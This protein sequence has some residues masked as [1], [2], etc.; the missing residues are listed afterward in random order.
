MIGLVALF[1]LFAAFVGLINPKWRLWLKP[2]SRGRFFGLS[3]AAGFVLAVLNGLL[4]PWE[5]P[6]TEVPSAPES[7]RESEPVTEIEVSQ[8]EY[9]EEWPFTVDHGT[10]DCVD[11]DAGLNAAAVF[12]APGIGIVALNGIARSVRGVLPTEEI[13]RDNPALPGTKVNLG[14]FIQLANGLCGH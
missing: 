7:S 6:E 10:L 12:R 11:N 5:M 1:V 2:A 3:L 9:G 13:W 4:T 14:P 8:A